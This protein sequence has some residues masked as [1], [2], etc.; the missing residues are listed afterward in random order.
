L[1]YDDIIVNYWLVR[2]ECD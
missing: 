1:L 2:F